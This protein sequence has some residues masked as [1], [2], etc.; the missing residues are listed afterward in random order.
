ML[1]TSLDT[2]C[3]DDTAFANSMAEC[4][5]SQSCSVSFSSTW[6]LES[7]RDTKAETKKAYI[8]MYC[9]GQKVEFYLSYLVV[10]R[11]YLSCGIVVS[12][13][14]ILLLYL[15]FIKSQYKLKT[16]ST[17]YFNANIAN[18]NS[19]GVMIS[20]FDE[21]MNI[22]ELKAK[23]VEHI[24]AAF[25]RANKECSIFDIHVASTNKKFL[26]EKKMF[27][28]KNRISA[29]YKAFKKNKY[30]EKE[31]NKKATGFDLGEMEAQADEFIDDATKRN[32]ALNHI[33]RMRKL[34]D[35]S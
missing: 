10:E 33:N 26:V 24:R 6:F 34:Q 11:W 17:K 32:R 21:K 30:W 29:S 35:K 13:V 4:F 15:L 14:I 7:C 9:A 18:V 23:L 5:N 19:Y 20:G 27:D 31:A 2:S 12:N 25:K 28:L 8:H 1:K 3:N 16:E 22:W